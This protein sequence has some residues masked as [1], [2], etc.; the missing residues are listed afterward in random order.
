MANTITGMVKILNTNFL[1]DQSNTITISTGTT[2]DNLYDFDRDTKWQSVGSNDITTETVTVTFTSAQT[3]SRIMLL[4]MNFDTFNVQYLNG[5][6][7]T[8]FTNVYDET[9]S[10]SAVYGTAV[11]GTGTYGG[12]NVM[13]GIHFSGNTDTTKYFEFDSVSTTQIRIQINT[14]ITANAEKEMVELYIGTETGTFVEDWFGAPNN[15]K[16]IVSNTN[17]LYLKKSNGGMIK[18]EKSDKFSTN[19]SLKELLNTADQ[20]IMNTMY[21]NGEFAIL[22]CGG[23]PYV[24]RGM[25]LQDFFHVV[26]EGNL[27]GEFAIGRDSNI[28]MNYNFV[29]WER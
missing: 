29:L 4:Q 25:R 12:G 23:V 28:G 15:N 18:Y 16:P 1:V 19:V 2:E 7:W 26:I 5:S 13:T 27:E 6:T 8:D 21:D 14:T 3:I 9:A 10:G 11:Y 17:A 24:Q 20:T 22:P